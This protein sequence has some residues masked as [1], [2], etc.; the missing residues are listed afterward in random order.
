MVDRTSVTEPA[1]L[2][3]REIRAL[4][5][6]KNAR[7]LFS[8]VAALLWIGVGVSIWFRVSRL[9]SLGEAFGVAH[10]IGDLLALAEAPP[11][12]IYTTFEVLEITTAYQV[13]FDI[14]LAVLLSVFL[15]V[16]YL[17]ARFTY[18]LW[19]LLCPEALLTRAG[20]G[21]S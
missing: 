18:K 6:G 5:R 7:W 15:L 13:C 3:P 17:Q 4:E 20:P 19:R 16:S 8:G 9:L 2:T 12:A 10:D 11:R 14:L 1:P 21:A